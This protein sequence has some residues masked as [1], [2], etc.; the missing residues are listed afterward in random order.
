MSTWLQITSELKR[1]P[2]EEMLTPTQRQVWETIC[3]LLRFPQHINLYGSAGSGKTTIAWAISRVTGA[4]HV[5]VP[6]DLAIVPSGS[7]ILLVDNISPQ[8]ASVRRVLAGC[9]LLNATSVILISRQP[10][11]LPM[12]RIEL[13][14]PTSEDI[15]T[16]MRTMSRIGI[17]ANVEASQV[18]DFWALLRACV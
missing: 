3:A 12:R 7:E 4:L 6:S 11:L 16:A 9:N 2:A 10:T 8:E 13:P 18:K 15:T 17:F 14:Q 5:S 1:R